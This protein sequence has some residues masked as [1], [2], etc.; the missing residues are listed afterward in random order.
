MAIVLFLGSQQDLVHIDAEQQSEDKDTGIAH[1]SG[2]VVVTYRDMRLEADEVTYDKNTG[3]V[4]AGNHIVYNRADEH[5]Q[6]D[7]LSLHVDSKVGDFTNV[8]GQVG[9]GFNIKAETAHRTEEGLYQLKNATVTTCCD[10]PRPGWT[11]FVAR[12][13]VDPHR[14]VTA[15]GSVFRLENMPVFYMPY[16]SLPSVDR[17]RS[18]GFLIPSTSTSTTKGRAVRESF[19]WAVNRSVGA[20]FSGEYF[21]KRGPAGAID[22]RA[23]PDATSNVH[24]ETLFAHDKLG[25]G[26]RSARILGWGDFP[27]G[28]HGVV[29]MNLVSSF[30]FRQVYEDGLNIISS[31]ITH[32]IGFLSRNKPNADVNFLYARNGVFFQDQPTV[33]L[34]NLPSL[35]LGIPSRRVRDLPLYFSADSSFSG[36]MR[37]DASITT[38]YV[39]RFDFYPSLDAPLLRSNLFD[40]NQR[41]SFRET[42]YSHSLATETTLG[43]AMNRFS[44]DYGSHFSGPALERD[45]GKFRHVIEPDINYRYIGDADHF[46]NTIV[47]DNVDL[48]TH[49]NEVEYGF[50]NRFFT[51]REIF[52][53]R[54]SQKYFLD[55]TFGGAIIPGRRNVFQPLLDITGFT[56]ADGQR[57]FSPIVSNMRLA[58]SPSTSEDI[59]VDYDT[60]DHL[61]RSAGVIGNAN[62]GQFTGGISYFFTRRSAIEVPSNELRGSLT[63]GNR[64]KPGF[65]AA[66]QVSY[67]VQHSLFQ[68]SV[69]EVGYNTSCFG[70]NFEVSQ[71]NIGARVESRFR[72]AFT[73]KDV[74]SFGT[75]R[76]RERL[77]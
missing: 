73:L 28:F 71:F 37:R 12:A 29:D 55:P 39:E 50:T 63:F 10:G 69:A 46:R 6:A 49:T 15:N 5:L 24:V 43:N 1:A 68:G 70:L 62:R 22:F 47:V 30:V 13:V 7:H 2:K 21:S 20:E 18:T 76:P 27:R 45:F 59:E 35:D 42:A 60:R 11:L 75:M 34:Q 48:V 40:W 72:F 17:Q 54:L 44:F 9:P 8:T 67:D 31:P 32:S 41:L 14:R 64:L 77:F 26:G 58:T 53:W 61:F 51:K 38:P 57:R 65:S 19:Y 52:S 74:G 33:V 3:I 25:Q 56:F 16:V 66:V 4:T 36:I 23:I